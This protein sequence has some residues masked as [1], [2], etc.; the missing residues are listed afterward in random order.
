MTTIARLLEQRSNGEVMLRMQQAG[1]AIIR[2]SGSLKLRISKG[3]TEAI[4]INTGGGIAGGDV[5]AV[6]AEVGPLATLT[7]TSQAAERVYRSLGPP[8]KIDVSLKAEA[9]SE[10]FWLPQETILFEQSALQRTLFV[11]LHEHATFLG[12]ESLL[13]GRLEMGENVTV[14]DISDH[15]HIK[16]AGKLLHVENLKLG[17]HFPHSIA[18][19]GDNR[20]MATVLLV[21]PDVEKMLDDVRSVLTKK[22]GASAWNGK[23]VA[24]LVAIDGFHLRKTLIKVL[25]ACAGGKPL[26]K[27][28]T[29]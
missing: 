28:W 20:A 16:R 6:N 4:L 29:F 14:L 7:V 1:P 15:W 27:T 12:V 3:S 13:F 17:P 23:L 24:R 9:G 18:T 8:A 21:S 19:L 26:P 10:L 11:D 5:I 25:M 22:D 2:E